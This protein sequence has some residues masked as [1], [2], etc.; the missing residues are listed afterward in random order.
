MIEHPRYSRRAKKKLEQAHQKVSRGKKGS[1]RR[2]KAKKQLGKAHRKVANQRRDFLHKESRKLVN[3]YQ[4]MVFEDIKVSNLV[5]KPQAK[6]DEE[7]GKS[8]PNGAAAKGGLNTSILDAGWGIFVSMCSS[9]AEGAGRTLIKVS[10]K[11]T[12]QIC[13]TCG[14]VRKKDLSERWHSCDCGAELDRDVNAALNILAR[15]HNTL[16]GGTHPTPSKV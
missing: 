1:H 9:K 14:T 11:F 8:L 2:N 15:G 5:R 10:P 3:Q 4:V 16:S 7:T 13:S 12:S 6:Q